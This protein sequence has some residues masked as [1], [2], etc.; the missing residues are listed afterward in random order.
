MTFRRFRPALTLT[1]AIALVAASI[2][3]VVPAPLRMLL[4]LGVGAPELSVW[5]ITIGALLAAAALFDVRSGRTGRLTL[6][7]ALLAVALSLVPLV[8]ARRP[9]SRRLDRAMRSCTR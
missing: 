8:R 3:I 1:A 6:A 4:P 9:R 7:L 2:W 5:L